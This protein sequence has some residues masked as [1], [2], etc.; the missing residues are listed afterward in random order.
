MGK[1]LGQHFLKN[2]A[3]LKKIA[4]ASATPAKNPRVQKFSAIIE[5]GPGHGELTAELCREYPGVPIIAIEKDKKMIGTLREK[6]CGAGNYA[7]SS[8]GNGAGN[9]AANNIKIE[10]G[11]AMEL[12]G[13]I[14]KKIGR[15]PYAVFGN[16]PY[17]ISGHLL[18]IIGELKNKP[19]LSVF[20]IQKEVAERIAAAPGNMNRLSAS[21]QFWAEPKILFN[22][23][24]GAFMPPPQVNSSVIMLIERV[25]GD[26]KNRAP[27]VPADKYYSLVRAIFK[28]PR[29]TIFNNLRAAGY[30]GDKIFKQLSLLDIRP[31]DRP[32]GLS[33]G[34][35]E[36]LARALS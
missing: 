35:I 27:A 30:E 21:V 22:V 20:L 31:E 36:A 24:P 16:I 3:T 2:T 34:K 1:F 13:N 5:I 23:P 10:E 14:A 12:I 33:I 6:F 18:R 8:A 25:M 15:K 29:K 11:D 17:Y 9:N 26:V 4:S 19:A 28:Q 32:S 7:G